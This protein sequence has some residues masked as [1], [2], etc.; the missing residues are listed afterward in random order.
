MSERQYILRSLLHNATI[1]A[2][3]LYQVGSLSAMYSLLPALP[4]LGFAVAAPLARQATYDG[5]PTAAV[6]NGTISGSHSNTY[7]QDYFLGIP[8]AQPPVESLR[9]RTPQSLNTTFD[10][11]EATSYSPTCVGYGVSATLKT[12][13]VP[14]LNYHL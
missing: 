14:M 1:L 8:Y 12:L 7:N 6:K 2:F 9:F 13:E 10:T 11:Y 3:A 5:I 4:L